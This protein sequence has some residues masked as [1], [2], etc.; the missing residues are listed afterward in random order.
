MTIL[1]IDASAKPSGSNTHAILD[2]IEARI[3]QADI[4]RDLGADAVPQIDGTWVG[5]NFTPAD[6]RSEDQKAT[7][8]LSDELVAEIVA[9]D[10]LLIALPIYNF[11]VPGSLKAW[12]DLVCRAGVTFKYTESGP[13]G[14]LEGKRAIVAVASG[15]TPVGSEIDFATPYMRHVLGFIGITD[16]TFVTADRLNMKEDDAVS[17]VEDQIAALAA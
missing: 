12:I 9:A 5:S 8:A 10:T 1:R 2:A 6:E 14:L 7:L 11:T 16:V 4:R 3:G 13:V 17:L 15:G